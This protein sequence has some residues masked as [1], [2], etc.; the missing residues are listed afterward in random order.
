MEA[1]ANADFAAT[2]LLAPET[3][4]WAKDGLWALETTNPNSRGSL[5]G[6]ILSESKADL[7]FVQETKIF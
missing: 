1:D 7:L 6:A 2:D 5:H 4:W 3:R